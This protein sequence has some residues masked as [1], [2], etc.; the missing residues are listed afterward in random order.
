MK[1]KRIQT[2]IRITI[3][4]LFIFILSKIVDLK[5]LKEAIQSIR[6]DIVLFAILLYFVN[7]AIRAYRWEIIFNK[8][9][10]RLS[11]KNAC[12]MTLIGIAL[13]IFIPATLGDIVKSYYGYK[14]YGMKEEMLL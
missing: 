6:I 11:F 1:A 12:M 13:N 7:I 14:I 9:E 8:D 2:V 4:I 10:S 3:F 5:L